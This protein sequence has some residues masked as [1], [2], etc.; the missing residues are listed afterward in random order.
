MTLPICNLQHYFV[1]SLSHLDLIILVNGQGADIV[2]LLQLLGEL[3]DMTSLGTCKGPLRWWLQFLLQSY[4]PKGLNF[5]RSWAPGG[6]K[7]TCIHMCCWDPLTLLGES[8]KLQGGWSDRNALL[9][10]EIRLWQS[11]FF[12][13]RVGLGCREC[14]KYV[15]S[16]LLLFFSCQSQDG[17]FLSIPSWEPENPVGLLEGKARKVW[18]H[19]TT[20]ATKNLGHIS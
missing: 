4:V 13:Y 2:L 16:L 10:G 3:A 7:S 8:W 18:G 9:A 6:L 15:S 17:I 19:H 1:V 20:V 12:P 11:F 5:M 14:L